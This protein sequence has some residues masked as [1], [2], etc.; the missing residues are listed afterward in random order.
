MNEKKKWII[1]WSATIQSSIKRNKR[2]AAAAN[3]IW[4]YYIYRK[5]P[6]QMINVIAQRR[7]KRHK[8][9]LKRQRSTPLRDITAMPGYKVIRKK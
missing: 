5:E 6:K 8:T 1:R 3:P 9:E 7:N 2:E 4:S